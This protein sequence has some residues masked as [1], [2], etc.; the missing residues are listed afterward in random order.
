MNEQDIITITKNTESL[1]SFKTVSVLQILYNEKNTAC[2][3]FITNESTDKNTLFNIFHLAY[4]LDEMHTHTVFTSVTSDDWSDDVE[5]DEDALFLD[6]VKDHLEIDDFG[7]LDNV[8]KD[9]A[10]DALAKTLLSLLQE[11]HSKATTET[12]KAFYKAREDALEAG[13]KKHHALFSYL[14]Q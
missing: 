5:V 2:Y 11:M 8:K 10:F 9:L 7:S 13:R 6:D 1:L 3:D 14:F 12:L 4:S